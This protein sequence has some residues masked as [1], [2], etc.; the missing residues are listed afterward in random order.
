MNDLATALAPS[1]SPPRPSPAI[2]LEQELETGFAGR[3]IRKK[4]RQ[5]V[6]KAG[7][8]RSDQLDIEQDLSLALYERFPRFDPT[9]APWHA[10]VATVISRF[11]ASLLAARHAQKR[12]SGCIAAS[13]NAHSVGDDG[14]WSDLSQIVESRHVSA[15]TGHHTRDQFELSL[16]RTELAAVTKRLPFDLKH[17]CFRLQHESVTEVS[18]RIRCSRTALYR[19]IGQLRQ[20]FQEAGLNEFLEDRRTHRA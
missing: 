7:F 10:F 4:A 5:L 2:D 9:I 8:T 3:Y 14:H 6:G 11:A 19:R 1:P 18:R 13:L 12:H 16:L 20:I 15:V 17:L